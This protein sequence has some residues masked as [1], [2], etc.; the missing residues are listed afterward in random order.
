MTFVIVVLVWFIIGYA[1]AF[2]TYR[3]QTFPH[4]IGAVYGYVGTFSFG[5]SVGTD[6]SLG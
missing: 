2:G 3:D 1:F 4:I 5:L 6:R